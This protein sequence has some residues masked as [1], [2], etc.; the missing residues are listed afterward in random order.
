MTANP[1][2]RIA[3]TEAQL[4]AIRLLRTAMSNEHHQYVIIPTRTT[5]TTVT[6]ATVVGIA[7]EIMAAIFTDDQRAAIL[8]GFADNIRRNLERAND[9]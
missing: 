3:T 1:D 2:P 6:L 4:D 9:Q 7:N 5:N 8:D